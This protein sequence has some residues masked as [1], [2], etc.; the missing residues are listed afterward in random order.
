MVQVRSKHRRIGLLG[1]TFNPIHLGHLILAQTVLETIDLERVIFIPSYLPPH[2][3]AAGVIDSEHRFR[4]TELATGDNSRFQISD[5]EVSRSG[6][7]YTIDTVKHFRSKFPRPDRLFFLIG[8]DSLATLHKW[9]YISELKKEVEFVSVTRPGTDI[10]KT[11]IKT[12]RV[13]MPEIEIS[14]S[15]IRKNRRSGKSIRYFVPGAVD[16]YIDEHAIYLA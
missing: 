11:K 2:K 6:K 4:M 15:M 3:S 8:Y 12:R 10:R 13:S 1:G 16:S 7:S 5:F 9:K 14:S